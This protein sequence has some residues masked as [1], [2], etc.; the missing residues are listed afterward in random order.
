MLPISSAFSK[1]ISKTIKIIICL[2]VY[3]I[4]SCRKFLQDRSILTFTVSTVIIS[5]LIGRI[6]M[7]YL[8]S[9]YVF[10]TL[11]GFHGKSMEPTINEGDNLIVDKITYRFEDPKVND[12]IGFRLH[13]GTTTLGDI[14]I[15]IPKG[16]TK[17]VIAVGGDIVCIKEN[18][19]YINEQ[20]VREIWPNYSE[21]LNAKEQY[22]LYVVNTVGIGCKESYKV[23]RNC[24]FV[25]GDGNPLSIDSRVIGAISKDMITGKVIRIYLPLNRARVFR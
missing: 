7:P 22:L 21:C 3:R 5:F 13:P 25:L 12:I 11:R 2:Q 20:F 24:Y 6:L 19:L 8:T 18:D 16:L 4:T 14:T 1:I 10:Q 15:E 9:K 17:R 23:P